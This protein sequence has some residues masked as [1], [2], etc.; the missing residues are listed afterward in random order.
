MLESAI[1]WVIE[2]TNAPVF[3]LPSFGLSE[4]IDILIV[5]ALLFT[6]I[7]WIKRTSAWVLL[8]GIALI[9][10]IA[11]AAEIFELTTVQWIVDNTIGMGLVVIVILFQP[12]LRKA[13]EQ[14]GRSSKI[15][16]IKTD[17]IEP[18]HNSKATVDVVLG[19]AAVLSST[20]TGALIV[21]EQDIDL[22][23][24]ERSGIPLDAQVSVQL[25]LNIFEKNT[26][27][28]DGA[29]IIKDNRVMAATCILP[30]AGE[31]LD[32]SYGTR[33]RAACGI[34]EVSDA[35]VLVVSEETGR[36]SVAIGGKIAS[37][38]N[39]ASMREL[40]LWGPKDKSM[41]RIFGKRRRKEK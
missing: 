21:L 26:P 29:V 12:E 2:V 33:H 14:I 25:L 22:G 4:L 32:S 17:P 24:Y 34:S 40:L 15:I 8:R 38:L 36:I 28:H 20:M 23:D 30:I 31:A 3:Y 11:L 41:L 37:N 13:L 16:N 19:A 5:A 35:R 9:L 1:N 7:K 18:A 10:V 39:E 27:L 6:V